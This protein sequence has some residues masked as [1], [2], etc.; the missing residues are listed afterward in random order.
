M[1]VG[2]TKETPQP[3]MLCVIH[4]TREEIDVGSRKSETIP[5]QLNVFASTEGACVSKTCSSACHS[6]SP[7]NF[8]ISGCFVRKKEK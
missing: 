5:S 2:K 4:I 1:P 6:V 7:R 8:T 3:L